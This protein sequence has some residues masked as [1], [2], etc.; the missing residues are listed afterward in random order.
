ME[1]VGLF[2]VLEGSKHKGQMLMV[3]EE[4]SLIKAKVMWERSRRLCSWRALKQKQR[5]FDLIHSVGN[6]QLLQDLEKGND[7][8]NVAF[9]K[10]NLAGWNWEHKIN[11]RDLLVQEAA[12][13]ILGDEA[14]DKTVALKVALFHSFLSQQEPSICWFLTK[15][16]DY[17]AKRDSGLLLS[18]NLQYSVGAREKNK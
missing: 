3:C 10:I 2:R 6:L 7:S 9:Y 13:V 8:I 18:W 17:N 5:N 12:T 14:P 11:L 4:A 16:E 1:A 15:H